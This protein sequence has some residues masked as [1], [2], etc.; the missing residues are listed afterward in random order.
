MR[1]MGYQSF[2]SP[3]RPRGATMKFTLKVILVLVVCA[4]LVY[5]IMHSMNKTGNYGGQTQ[6]VLGY[7]AVLFGRKGLDERALPGLRNVNSVEDK[8]SSNGRDDDN[9]EQES[10]NWTNGGNEV[11]HELES[12]HTEPSSRNGH[13]G[14]SLEESGKVFIERKLDHK[15][16]VIDKYQKILIEGVATSNKKGGG[17]EELK[18]TPNADSDFLAKEDDKDTRTQDSMV[19]GAMDDVLSFHDENGVPPDGN[20]TKTVAHEDNMS[21]VSQGIRLGKINANKVTFGEDKGLEVSLEG[22]ENNAAAVEEFNS[23]A[24]THGDISG[25]KDRPEIERGDGKVL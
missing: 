5:Q 17:E 6:H 20:E 21:K 10:V 19:E 2:G 23:Q 24:F 14:S 8:G 25:I 9:T 4:W 11:E 22:Q 13:N 1:G 3:Q 12:Q 7:G 15:D 18:E 16:H